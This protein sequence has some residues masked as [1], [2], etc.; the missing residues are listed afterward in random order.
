MAEQRLDEAVL[1]I[2]GAADKLT[3]ATSQFKGFEGKQ[4]ELISSVKIL[5]ERVINL[6]RSKPK[7][8]Q[9][10]SVPLYERVCLV[11]TYSSPN[12]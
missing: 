9:D 10:R 1:V 4:D 5:A 8:K 7:K 11:P 12:Y 3:S 6:E 2:Q